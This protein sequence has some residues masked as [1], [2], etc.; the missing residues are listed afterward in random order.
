MYHIDKGLGSVLREVIGRP[1]LVLAR[2]GCL[3]MRDGIVRE[4]GRVGQA[5][6]SRL[7]DVDKD[8]RT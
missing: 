6:V 3:G 4:G 1:G 7:T 2:D 5:S 8:G